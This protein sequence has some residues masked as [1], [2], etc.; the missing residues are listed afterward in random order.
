MRTSSDLA[1]AIR[2][3]VDLVRTVAPTIPLPPRSLALLLRH[4]VLHR[5][6]AAT[7]DLLTE[8]HS[9]TCFPPHRPALLVLADTV[10]RR[11]E[12]REIAQLLPVLADHGV[13]ANAHVYNAL[14]KA[15]CAASDPAG[16][17]G[18]LRRMKD[19]GVEP[20]LVTYYNTLIY[21]LARARMITKA[22]TYLDINIS[23]NLLS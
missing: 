12:L 16:V 23:K 7:R 5:S 17:L 10:C 15:H 2:T 18:V 13:K 20:D 22:R 19:D 8:L 14:M 11:G 3:A 6:V 4:L 9:P 21:G 1:A